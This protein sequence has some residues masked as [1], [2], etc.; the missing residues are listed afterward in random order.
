MKRTYLLGSVI[1]GVLILLAVMVGLTVAG[2]FGS[3]EIPVLVFSSDSAESAY[4]AE[5]LKASGWRLISGKLKEGHT[6]KASTYGSQTEVGIS[7]N[8][9]SVEIF[10]ENNVNVTEEYQIELKLGKIKVN[11]RTL[12]ILTGSATKEYDGNPLECQSYQIISGSLVKGHT[13]AVEYGI[14]R[15][16]V[17]VSENTVVAKV[18]DGKTEVSSNYAV[19]II[20]G[21][22][23][24][25][26]Y[27]ITISTP[28]AEGVYNG[29]PLTYDYYELVSGEMRDGDKLYVTVIGS[30]TEAGESQNDIIAQVIS[31]SGTDVTARYDIKKELGTLLVKPRDI[32]VVTEGKTAVYTGSPIE[33]RSYTVEG[34]LVE[35]HTI[36]VSVTG[37]QTD[38]GVSNNTFI[39]EIKDKNGNIVTS[40]YNVASALGQL[41][42]LPVDITITSSSAEKDYDTLPLTSSDYEITF[43][44]LLPGHIVKVE[45]TGEQKTVGI[46]ENTFIYQVTDSYGND[47]TELY[48]VATIFGTLNIKPIEITLRTQGGEKIYDGTPL[49]VTGDDTWS[50]SVGQLYTGHTIYVEQTGAQTGA[51]TS[52]NTLKYVMLDENGVDVTSCYL[53]TEDFGDL[54][55]NPIKLTIKT[56]GDTRPYNGEELTKNVW[57]LVGGTVLEGH[58]LEVIVTGTIKYVGEVENTFT[59]IIVDSHGTDVTENYEVE[60]VCGTLR[61]LPIELT[62]ATD[63]DSKVYDGTP[64]VKDGWTLVG[65]EIAPGHTI[66]VNVIGS[67]T[68][69]GVVENE[70]SYNVYDEN[71]EDITS[72]YYINE[73]LGTLEV[74]PITITIKTGSDHK[75][76]DRQPLVCHEYELTEG[77]LLEGHTLEVEF[78][79]SITEVGE[80]YNTFAFYVYD[81]N[82]VNLSGNYSATALYGKL[83]I[84][85]IKI[86]VYT[87]S[88]EKVY[89]GTP[90]TKSGW[91]INYGEL[92]SGDEL[93]VTP[94]G[95]QTK[96]GMGFNQATWYIESAEGV[97]ISKN[98]NVQI[99]PGPLEVTPVYLSVTSEGATKMYDGE[100]LRKEEYYVTRGEVVD[101]ES[102]AVVFNLF[103]TEA[104]TYEN[105]MEVIIVNAD[106]VDVTRNY[107]INKT[108]GK[109]EISKRVVTIRTDSAEK[110]YDGN[111]LT[112]PGFTIVSSTKPIGAHTVFAVINGSQTEV[113][114]SDNIYAE[115]RMIDENGQD[116]TANY[117]LSGAQLGVLTVRD[118]SEAPPPEEPEPPVEDDGNTL[119]ASVMATSQGSVYLR[120]MSFGSYNGR[121]FD[122]AAPYGKTFDGSFGMSYLS[123]LSL[124]GAVSDEIHIKYHTTRYFLPEYLE[125]TYYDY[126]VQGSDVSFSDTGATDARAYYYAYQ[127]SGKNAPTGVPSQYAGYEEEYREFVY[128]NYLSVPNTTSAYLKRIIKDQG[129][130]KNDP[131]VIYKVAKYIQG[132]A[133][134]NLDFNKEMETLEDDVVIAFLEKYK[135]GVCRH[136]AA[137]A[138]LLLR[139]LGIP[140]RYTVGVLLVVENAGEWQDVYSKSSH[141]WTEVYIDG[142][143]WLALEVTAGYETGEGEGDGQG[144]GNGG[145]GGSGGET[146]GGSGGETGGGDDGNG[147]NGGNGGNTGNDSEKPDPTKPTILVKPVDLAMKYRDGETLYP[148]GELTGDKA[149]RELLSMGYTYECVVSGERSEVGYGESIIESFILKDRDGEDVTDL[150]NVNYAKGRLHVYVAELYISSHSITTLYTGEPIRCEKYDATGLLRGH[151]LE[152]TFTGE[153]IEAGSTMNSYIYKIYDADGNDASYMYLVKP[154]YGTIKVEQISI[155]IEADS[156]VLTLDELTALGGVYYAEKWEI[157]SGAVLE[158]HTV[159]VVLDG[160]ID[161]LGRCDSIIVSVIIR[162]AGGVDVTKCYS[163]TYVDGEMRV[164]P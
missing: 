154:S 128:Q 17:G 85:P 159:E 113:G 156:T 119:L 2:V 121:G 117:D 100:P 136:Y 47:V 4:N 86:V 152:I 158:G 18:L 147:G 48:N 96:V 130:D 12:R 144:G 87:E 58:H 33:N 59:P 155:T 49:T 102:L 107:E 98:Y 137:A 124:G 43:G 36:Y 67:I 14:K 57:E 101:G 157:T 134:Y 71:G 76:Y 139:E 138:T 26:G 150:F 95:S 62:I 55:V 64:L 127:Y 84:E 77:A 38:V 93:F 78:N 1:L 90:L 88:G 28:S 54:T 46:G 60:P 30:Q 73:S 56:E 65:G 142:V 92:L 82:G 141:A 24:V 97:D 16:E 44:K 32:Y 135:E 153:K 148:N 22:L 27:P 29:E 3:D 39:A 66:V 162:D 72:T 35:G 5:P 122:A 151:T 61:V 50:I 133:E 37:K 70:I 103:P 53:V 118:P 123:S 129:F 23:T 42:V 83:R 132:A 94:Y 52:P 63:S 74:T 11:P 111:P 7:E 105:K 145:N 160:Y 25:T 110:V 161:D 81:E 21:K 109:L 31:P 15:T 91:E 6:V 115:L 104:G 120:E 114:K 13:L 112:A 106:G 143:G 116:I 41:E 45:I 69:V 140:A 164:K 19:E 8:S 131:Q 149:F 125:P 80:D 10:D 75:I 108:Y 34:S 89:D 68:N 146:G 9:L 163:I 99:N 40:N 126:R 79:N 20:N 51:G